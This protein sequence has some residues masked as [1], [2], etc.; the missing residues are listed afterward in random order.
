MKLCIRGDS[1]WKVQWV[2]IGALTDFQQSLRWSHKK[3]C[4]HIVDLEICYSCWYGPEVETDLCF[5]K[6]C[7]LKIL[8]TLRWNW[9]L[10]NCQRG[11]FLILVCHVAAHVTWRMKS[12][13]TTHSV[14][15]VVVCH[16]APPWIAPVVCILPK[17]AQLTEVETKA[18]SCHQAIS[19]QLYIQSISLS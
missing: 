2:H 9:K 11:F 6:L 19:L 18:S 1:Q 3:L 17:R 8:G 4:Y 13:P 12:N 15:V 10:I 5:E 7:N 16:L 14:V